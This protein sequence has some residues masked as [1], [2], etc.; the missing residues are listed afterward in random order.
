M[1]CPKHDV[2]LAQRSTV[3]EI[4]KIEPKQMQSLNYSEVLQR[5]TLVTFI[6]AVGLAKTVWKPA[7]DNS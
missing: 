1:W 5:Q 4:F 2:L 7:S 6:L 3:T